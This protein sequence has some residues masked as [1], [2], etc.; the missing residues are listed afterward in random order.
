[1]SK[2]NYK[3]LESA[4]WSV[5]FPGFGQLLNK[6]YFKGILL[7]L[8]EFAIN[9][10]A[11]INSAIIES[12]YGNIQ[13]SI[14]ITNYSWLMFYPCIYLFG[15]YDAYRDGLDEVP[16]LIFLPFVL[17]A[18][19]TTISVIYSKSFNIKGIYLGPIFLPILS[20]FL[21]LSL[22]FKIRKIL[23]KRNEDS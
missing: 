1:M 7:M 3:A 9:I 15:I 6:K 20:I 10:N 17:A 22:G 4:L 18:Y 14:N 2:N 8:S 21:S 12:F 5:A 16:P 11:N 13:K 23:I 19:I